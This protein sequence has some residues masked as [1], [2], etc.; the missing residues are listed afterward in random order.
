MQLLLKLRIRVNNNLVKTGELRIVVTLCWSEKTGKCWGVFDSKIN[1]DAHQIG[2][3]FSSFSQNKDLLG[4]MSESYRDLGKV[5]IQMLMD[6]ISNF[7]FMDKQRVS[8]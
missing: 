5:S 2:T 7:Q 8:T 4:T 6:Q 1:D 3:K